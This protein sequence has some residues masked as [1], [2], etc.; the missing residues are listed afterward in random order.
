MT[1]IMKHTLKY[2]VGLLLLLTS[3]SE[4]ELKVYHGSN[5]IYFTYMD[6]RSQQT[7]DFNF[8]TEAP[9]TRDGKVKARMTL[10]GYLLDKDINCH[11]SAV[12]DKSTAQE[13][14]DYM[15][16][17]TGTFHKG[18]PDDT[19]EVT[20]LRNRELLNT[21]YTLTLCLDSAEDCLIGPSEYR[22]VTIN[23]TDRVSEPRWWE[24]SAAANLGKYSDM[25][26][27][28]FIIFMDGKILESLDEYTGI[29]FARLIARFKNWWK[30]QW[31][32]GNYQ[33]YDTDGTTPLYETILDE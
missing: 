11:I 32:Q 23:V 14:I 4:E 21:N 3:C 27:R 29:E 33:Y 19:Y 25:K 16:L 24:Q 15:P 12:A 31:A 17:K 5:Y 28:V 20:V 13:N 30:E 6:D 7:I 8:A 26:Y 1:L 18:Q 9:L 2:L 10:L 22:Y